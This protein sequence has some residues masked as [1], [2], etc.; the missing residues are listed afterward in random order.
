MLTASCVSVRFGDN[1]ILDSASFSINK[2]DCVGLV[3]P[4]GAGKSTLLA[5]L[6][7]LRRPD[8]GSVSVMA[9]NQIRYL[10]QGFADLDGG[11]LRDLID[12]Q[13]EG[14]LRAHA[15]FED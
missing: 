6:A 12:A 4:N 1:L 11:T 14:L 10:P 2:H 3:G 7:G 9:G 13:L 8:N 5:V 15:Q